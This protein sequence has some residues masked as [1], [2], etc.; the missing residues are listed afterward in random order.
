ML[1]CG[2]GTRIFFPDGAVS[3]L[4]VCCSVEVEREMQFLG[5][6][7]MENQVKPESQEIISILRQAKLRTVM[8]TGMSKP[9]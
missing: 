8:V 2:S 9:Q 3:C 4:F 5:L 1:I 6:L 7:V